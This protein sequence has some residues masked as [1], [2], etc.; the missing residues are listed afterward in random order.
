M[1]FLSKIKEKI[2]KIIR[3]S[4]VSDDFFK[5]LE[6]TLIEADFGVSLSCELVAFLKKNISK[7][8]DES[9]VLTMLREKIKSILEP[10]HLKFSIPNVPSS[11]VF[12]GVNGGGKTTTIAKI[13]RKLVDNKNKVHIAACDTFRVSAVE[14]LEFWAKKI[15][16]TF[17][18]G[19]I[20]SDPASIAYESASK[21]GDAILLIDT[22]GRLSNNHNLMNE[23]SKIVR[24]LNKINN[25]FPSEIILVLDST[26][27]QYSI[28]QVRGFLQYVKITGIFLAKFDGSAKCGII[29]SI[30]RE[31]G[32]PII[33]I[34]TGESEY[35]V[36]DFNVEDFLKKIF[37]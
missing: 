8:D 34:G 14:Q 18:K 28:E 3:N 30:V 15:G 17:F 31:F 37:D 12:V 36:M 13:A 16:C 29:V 23:L 4:D 21:S 6:E 7:K 35:D 11:I 5:E 9:S 10:H 2:Y 27:G 19:S 26:V 22:S 32:I 24:V 20:N 1:S 25:S 33:G